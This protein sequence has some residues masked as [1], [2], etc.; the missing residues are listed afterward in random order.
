MAKWRHPYFDEYNTRVFSRFDVDYF[1][2]VWD[3]LAFL[4]QPVSMQRPWQ[5][6]SLFFV[7]CPKS[8]DVLQ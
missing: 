5:A 6:T 8:A 4:F 3:S 2:R 7:H 1:E